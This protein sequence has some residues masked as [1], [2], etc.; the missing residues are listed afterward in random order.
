MRTPIKKCIQKPYFYGQL[1]CD[2][3][4]R[5]IFFNTPKGNYENGVT[6]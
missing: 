1:Y 5:Y 2:S 3:P 4:M 6:F